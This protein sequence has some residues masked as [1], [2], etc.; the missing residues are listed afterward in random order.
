MEGSRVEMCGAEG[1][2]L[3]G[4]RDSAVKAKGQSMCGQFIGLHPLGVQ[5]EIRQGRGLGHI[6]EGQELGNVPKGHRKPLKTSEQGSDVMKLC[7]QVCHYGVGWRCCRD[8]RQRGL[9]WQDWEKD[10]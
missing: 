9:P 6:L 8:W 4:R 1:G 10:G 7:S 3:Q 5:W 2:A